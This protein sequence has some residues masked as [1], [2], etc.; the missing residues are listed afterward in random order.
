MQAI[1]TKYYGPT[2]K[3]WIR[4]RASCQAGS[5]TM[6]QDNNLNPEQNHVKAA[7]LL[8]HKLGWFHDSARGDTY[9]TWAYGGTKDGY[10][11]MCAV[12]GSEVRL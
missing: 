5:I 8:I 2:N 6:P 3:R 1:V 11:F 10:V 12:P 4:Y 7:K 9:G